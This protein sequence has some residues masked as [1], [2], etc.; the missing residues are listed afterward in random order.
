MKTAII[1]FDVE[2]RASYGYF[3]ARGDELTIC[4]QNTGADV[5]GGVPVVL[6]EHYLDD[7]GRFDLVVRTAGLPP[8][9]ILEK[10]PGIASKITTQINEFFQ[11]SP[12]KNIIGVTGTKGK[13]TTSTLIHKM[14]TAAGKT[15][16][17]GGNI[18]VPPFEFLSKLQERDWVVLELSSFQ[19][20][21]LRHS[22]AIGVC[23]MVFPEHLNW[24]LDLNEY[25]HAKSQM[26]SRQTAEDTA[27]SFADNETSRVIVSAGQGRKLPYFA[28]PGAEVKNG[29]IN[30]EGKIICGTS[31][32]KLLGSHNWQNACAAVTA[33][34]QVTHDVEA[35]RSVLTSFTGLEHRLEFVTE[36]GG[37]KYFDD[38][39]GTTPQTAIVAIEAFEAPEIVIVGGRSKG[40]PFDDLAATIA[41]RSNVKKVITFGETGPLIAGLLREAG[42]QDIISGG[43]NMDDIVGQAYELADPGDFVILAPACESFDMFENYKDRGEQ[44]KAAVRSLA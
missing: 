2:G 28:A 25:Y 35:I 43:P 18:G 16:Y 10:N 31:E 7:L 44:F 13:G 23:L 1:G 9:K 30:I 14:L 41:G 26:F 8:R 42:F 24:H 19:L 4:D 22:P 11:A 17:I 34:W 6:G 20:I 33:A 38:S 27:I 32:L 5:P 36:I 29:A 15:A 12:T 21:D 40:V 3:K 37:V 39:F